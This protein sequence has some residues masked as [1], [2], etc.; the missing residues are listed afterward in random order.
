MGKYFTYAGN[1]IFDA[2]NRIFFLTHSPLHI[3]QWGFMPE[4]FYLF[5]Q[6][7]KIKLFDTY[8][9]REIKEDK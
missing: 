5:K 2:H 4:A 6:I 9:L 8:C 1:L 7:F 3:N